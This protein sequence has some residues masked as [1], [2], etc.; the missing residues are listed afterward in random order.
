MVS[1]LPGTFGCL[2]IIAD[3]VMIAYVDTGWQ[4]GA[5]FLGVRVLFYVNILT[6]LKYSDA[7]PVCPLLWLSLDK[8]AL[9]IYAFYEGC[10]STN[11]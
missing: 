6:L 2:A 11:Q 8:S 7:I 1:S 9:V 10:D 3:C 4:D 5:C